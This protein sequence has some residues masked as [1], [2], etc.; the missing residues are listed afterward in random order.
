MLARFTTF[1]A[2]SPPS[3]RLSDIPTGTGAC[4]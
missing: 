2:V 1:Q 4:Q 3:S